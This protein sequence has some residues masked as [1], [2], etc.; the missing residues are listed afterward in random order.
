MGR[1]NRHGEH[2][3]LCDMH[4]TSIIP[5][6]VYIMGGG[7]GSSAR[8]ALKHKSMEKVVMC[9]IDKDAMQRKALASAAAA[10]ALEEANATECII[11]NLRL[12]QMDSNI[13][14]LRFLWLISKGMKIPLSGRLG[15]SLAD[16]QGESH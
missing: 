3:S 11:R 15:C 12:L 10:A 7:E 4:C 14:C 9:D 2:D 6:T 5:K 8:E 13:E 1:E 16:L